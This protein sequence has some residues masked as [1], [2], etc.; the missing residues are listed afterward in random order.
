M[1]V[2]NFLLLTQ[3]AGY[4]ASTILSLCVLIPLIVNLRD[5]KGNCLLYT[6]GIFLDTGDFVPKWASSG[7]CTYTTVLSCQLNLVS[8]I[9]LTRMS[10]F[11]RRGVDRYSNIPI[12]IE[13]LHYLVTFLVLLTAHSFRRF[14]IQ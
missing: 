6:S 9:Q 3:I 4:A 8:L 7:Y 5:M 14:G 11:L 10:Y 2:G 13:S 1:A 12:N